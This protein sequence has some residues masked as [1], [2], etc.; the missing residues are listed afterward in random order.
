MYKERHVRSREEASRV[1]TD[2]I[3]GSTDDGKEEHVPALFLNISLKKFY[4]VMFKECLATN[5]G[6]DPERAARYKRI[7]SMITL[8]VPGAER[9][10]IGQFLRY[11]NGNCMESKKS[12]AIDEKQHMQDISKGKRLAKLFFIDTFQPMLDKYRLSR[13]SVVA[14]MCSCSQADNQPD[15]DMD[16][17]N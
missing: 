8:S 9:M 15:A 6:K 12:E 3:F 1:L 5:K 14:K 4:T 10:T 16:T 7:Y 17:D 11:I 2:I 13:E